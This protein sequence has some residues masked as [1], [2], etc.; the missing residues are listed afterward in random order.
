MAE[1]KVGD[2]VYIISGR[3]TDG[4]EGIDGPYT[5][6]KVTA[7]RGDVTLDGLT[8][9]FSDGGWEKGR[10]SS[11]MGRRRI[12]R[13]D[14]PKTMALV[15]RVQRT[16]HENYLAAAVD[17]DRGTPVSDIRRRALNIVAECDKHLEKWPEPPQ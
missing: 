7:K 4:L 12:S 15:N 3:Q 5:V 14:D 9:V 10:T 16:R 2:E 8:P 13:T 17:M 11:W 6:A 1:F